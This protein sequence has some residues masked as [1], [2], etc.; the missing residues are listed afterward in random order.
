VAINCEL[1]KKMVLVVF[2]TRTVSLESWINCGLYDREKLLYEKHLEL[3]N[4]SKIYWLTYGSND[5]FLSKKL[6]KN[7]KMHINIE[8]V[9]MHRVFNIPIIG[10]YIYSLLS[11]FYHANIFL[12]S[13]V[14]KTQQMD[15]AWSAIIAKL[16]YKK[17]LIIRTGYTQSIFFENANISKLKVQLSRVLEK[18]S[19]KFCDAA[20]VSS[21]QDKQ[22]LIDK[23]GVPKEKVNVVH[24]YVDISI[25]KPVNLN[26]Y[27]NRLL[28]I[29]RLSD[30]KNLFNLID[31]VS[32][33]GMVLDVYGQGELK[34]EL[35]LFS[36]K[37]KVVVNFN[38]VVRNIDLPRIINSYKFYILP[39]LYEGTPKTLIEAMACGL[40]CIG[41]NVI[42][43]REVINDGLNGYLIDGTDVESIFLTLN[44]VTK[45][46][47]ESIGKTATDFISKHYSLESHVEKENNI[48]IEFI[49]NYKRAHD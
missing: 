6:K 20:I 9:G 31:A 34:N 16:I 32:K 10:S 29:G 2:F 44:K 13:D 19:Y 41:T 22:Y 37:K 28:F 36:Q 8:V 11:P 40:I 12:N 7:K 49:N 23:Y 21:Y 35:K 45:L 38:R 39:S 4:F 46:N 1:Y 15:G 26:K 17:P 42:G 14:L 18:I 48:F 27:D 5:Y 47:N 3:G 25:F 24:N 43:T 33:T 30:Q